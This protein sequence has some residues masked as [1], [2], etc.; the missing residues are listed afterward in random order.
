MLKEERTCMFVCGGERAME[1]EDDR[2]KLERERETEQAH[3][4]SVCSVRYTN[5]NVK[6]PS[7]LKRERIQRGGS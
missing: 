5:V 6:N 2:E 3:Y 7:A 4:L 1:N